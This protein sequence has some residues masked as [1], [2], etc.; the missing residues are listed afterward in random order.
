MY[1]HEVLYEVP[2]KQIVVT[3]ALNSLP[4]TEHK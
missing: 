2:H 4:V 3:K 1:I